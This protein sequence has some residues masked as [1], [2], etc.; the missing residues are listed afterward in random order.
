[1]ARKYNSADDHILND[2]DYAAMQQLKE[3]WSTADQ[4]GDQAGKDAAHRA[5]EDIRKRYNYSGGGDGTA[6]NALPQAPEPARYSAPQSSYVS[7]YSAQVDQL[8]GELMGGPNFSYNHETDPRYQQY[9]KEYTR[10]GQRAMQDTLGQVS[11]RTGGLASSYATTAASQA[12]EE[13]MAALAAK[14]PELEQLAY[15]MYMDKRNDKRA[16]LST[17]MGLE[18]SAY[19][20]WSD[21]WNRE[22]LIGRDQVAD[23][24]TSFDNQM[25]MNQFNY[26]VEQDQYN[27][28]KEIALNLAAAGDHSSLGELWG[29]SDRQTQALIDDYARQKNLT[30]QQAARDLADWYAQYGDFSKLKGM[31]VN[32]SAMERQQYNSLYGG[33][34]KQD[35]E[36]PYHLESL[37]AQMKRSGNPYTYLSGHRNDYGFDASAL[38][39]V[40]KEYTSWEQSQRAENAGVPGTDGY[41][42]VVSQLSRVEDMGIPDSAKAGQWIDII[43]QGYES[44][45]INE[46][47]AKRLMAQYGLN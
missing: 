20:R 8:L 28:E 23:R 22:R 26:G 15:S 43:E 6:Y 3:S 46:S 36:S 31:G 12:N 5:A 41:R 30:D 33:K 4:A 2:D 29:L 42:S 11:A 27:K 7:P 45:K 18:D 1:M 17:L 37:F 16:N 19:G 47:E 40:M 44:G 25:R 32:T 38:E 24:Q 13:Y 21:Q 39:G 9:E 35:E 10:L 14:I 34:N